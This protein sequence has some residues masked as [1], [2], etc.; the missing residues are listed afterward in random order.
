VKVDEVQQKPIRLRIED[1][2]GRLY[3]NFTVNNS[4]GTVIPVNVKDLPSGTYLL[5]IETTG[6]VSVQQFVVQ[7]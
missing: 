5:K 6:Q 2:S 3:K 4:G 7:K 1:A